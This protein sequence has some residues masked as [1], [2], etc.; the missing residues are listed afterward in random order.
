MA[1]GSYAVEWGANDTGKRRRREKHRIKRYFES[2][3]PARRRTP[4]SDRVGLALSASQPVRTPA[5]GRGGVSRSP[6][7]P[8]APNA[9][10]FQ[11]HELAPR[12]FRERAALRLAC[13]RPRLRA[14]APA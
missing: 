13:R 11:R 5:D 14:R 2:G 8:V 1:A 4:R 10:G 6:A 3:L 9:T 12:K 7:A